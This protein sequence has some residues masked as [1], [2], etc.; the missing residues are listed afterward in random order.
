MS[1]EQAFF[2]ELARILARSSVDHALD[3][4][5]IVLIGDQSLSTSGWAGA[6][7]RHVAP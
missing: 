7:I 3:P 1:G 6:R 5:T 4:G 2:F